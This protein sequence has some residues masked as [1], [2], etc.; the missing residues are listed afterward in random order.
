MTKRTLKLAGEENPN[1]LMTEEEL[2]KLHQLKEEFL[3]SPS[4]FV[5]L[6]WLMA[7]GAKPAD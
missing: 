6:T 1:K 7:C 5:L 2:T 4:P 3:N